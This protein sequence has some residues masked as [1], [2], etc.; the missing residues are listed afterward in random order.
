MEAR[1][2]KQTNNMSYDLNLITLCDHVVFRELTLID[3][4]FRS[5]RV[6]SPMGASKI[7][8]FASDDLVPETMYDIVND[9]KESDPLKQ[10]MIYLKKKWRSPNDF[11]EVTYYTILNYCVKCNGSK[12]LDDISYDVKGDLLITRD[13]RLLMQNVEKFVITRINSNS[14]HTFIGTS[15]ESLIG[16]RLNNVQLMVTQIKAEITRGLQKLQDMQSQLRAAGRTVTSGEMLQSIDNVSV[17]Q[18]VNDPTIFRADITVT[19][20]SGK[21]VEF[22]QFIRLRG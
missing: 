15:I 21:T 7:V 19:A 11:F 17:I 6:Q 2:L 4:D 8:L 16:T 3:D 12:Y 10:K 13:E 9:F 5:I 20:E 14:F 22:A 1:G 18:D